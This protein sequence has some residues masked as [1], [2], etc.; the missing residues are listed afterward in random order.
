MIFSFEARTMDHAF[1]YATHVLI[2]IQFNENKLK[3]SQNNVIF[4]LFGDVKIFVGFFF[5]NSFENFVTFL[6]DSHNV[7]NQIMFNLWER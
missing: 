1:I 6:Y 4:A 2:E 3:R 5:P 7:N